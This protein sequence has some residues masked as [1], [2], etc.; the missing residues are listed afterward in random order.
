MFM[1]TPEVSRRQP[2]GSWPVVVDAPYATTFQ[3]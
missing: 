2:D 1:Q 3:S